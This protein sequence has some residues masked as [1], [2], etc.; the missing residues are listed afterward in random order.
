MAEEHKK[1]SKQ[2]SILVLTVFFASLALIYVLILNHNGVAETEPVIQI[3]SDIEFT[4]VQNPDTTKYITVI[5]PTKPLDILAVSKHFYGH[6]EYW[7]YIYKDNKLEDLLNIPKGV[8][9]KI[10]R[11]DSIG[12]KNSLA[13]AKLLGDNLLNKQ[14]AKT[15]N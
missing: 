14:F 7:S 6:E 8:V 12:K 5:S 4:E 3:H 1:I 13:K 15:E 9:I 2:K 10:P 11:I